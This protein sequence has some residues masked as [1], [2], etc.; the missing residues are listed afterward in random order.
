VEALVVTPRF[1]HWHHA[2]ER[3][4]IDRNFAVHFP[5][6]DLFFGTYY[7]P[8][9]KWPSGYGIEGHPV[10]EGFLDQLSHPF[11]HPNSHWWD[12]GLLFIERKKMHPKYRDRRILGGKAGSR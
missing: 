9:G 5:W 12:F 7:A 10:P 4:A 6:I 11:H 8:P 1:H 3:E 2:I